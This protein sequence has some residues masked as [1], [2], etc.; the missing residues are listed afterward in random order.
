MKKETFE[1]VA[2]LYDKNFKETGF[3]STSVGWPTS[4]SHKLRFDKLTSVID[5]SESHFSINDFGCGYGALLQYLFSYKNFKVSEFNGYDISKEMLKGA[6]KNLDEYEVEVNLF[7]DKSISTKADYTFVSGT[8]NVRCNETNEAWK[9]HIH[10]SL[11]NINDYSKKG[12][13]FN[14]LSKYVDWK[15][16]DLFYGDPLYWFDHCKKHYSKHVSLLHDY[17]L[18]EWTII[19]KKEG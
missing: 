3:N 11:E 16:D 12:F 13:S 4:E 2:S 19:V 1:K 10:N 5:Q 15:K 9:K 8:Y 18:F 7:N 17:P 14:L 6:K